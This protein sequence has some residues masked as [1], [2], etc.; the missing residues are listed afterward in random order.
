LETQKKQ[1]FYKAFV[2]LTRIY[3]FACRTCGYPAHDIPR[4]DEKVAAVI[5]TQDV[6]RALHPWVGSYMLESTP[7]SEETADV[8]R[9]YAPYKEDLLKLCKRLDSFLFMALRRYT[10]GTMR[11]Y[12]DSGREARIR[13]ADYP[14]LTDD[15]LGVLMDSLSPYSVNFELLKNYSMQQPSLSALRVLYTR[16]QSFQTAEELAAIAR[17]VR[18]CHPRERYVSWLPP[19]GGSGLPLA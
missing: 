8:L 3:L 1:D 19:D 17:T 12:L 9:S 4:G 10:T 5:R 11:V 2:I 16:Y 15:V 6:S 14:L 18:T 13:M 7:L